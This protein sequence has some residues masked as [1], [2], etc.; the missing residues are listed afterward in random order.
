MN[1]LGIDSSKKQ[2]QISLYCENKFYTH[3]MDETKSH[4]EF[5]L[6][7]IEDFLFE[8]NLTIQQIENFSVNVGP[9]SFTGVRIG[10]SFVKA[11]LCAL[12]AKAVKINNFELINYNIEK[13]ENDYYIVLSSNNDDFYTLKVEKNKF[14]YGYTN[15]QDLNEIISET[16][17]KVYCNKEEKDFFEGILNLN[18]VEVKTDTFLKLSKQKIESEDFCDI[19]LLSPLYIK[20]SQAEM[21]LKTSI[22]QNLEIKDSSSLQD[23]VILEQKCFDKPYSLQILKEDL[24]NKNRHQF[25]AYFKNELVGYVSFEQIFDEINLFKI[26]VL[27]EFREY[28]IATKLMQKLINY[29]NDNKNLKKIFLEVNEKNIKAI[30]LYEK[31]GFQKISVR[32]NYY[33]NSF[34]AIIYERTKE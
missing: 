1:I 20:K 26:C 15:K 5:L 24:E 9:G 13:K 31:F 28:K 23:L 22:E 19:N 27:P 18:S 25:F 4:S 14:V 2:A 34:D 7:E 6:K 29:F 3:F 16:N 32:K 33:Q 8:H 17:Q 11:F 21:G 12:N 30:N 10:V